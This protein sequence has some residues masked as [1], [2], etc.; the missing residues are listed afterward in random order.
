M[1]KLEVLQKYNERTPFGRVGYGAGQVVDVNEKLATW[2]KAD[3][4]GTFRDYV[5]ET[6][7]VEEPPMNKAVQSPPKTKA[8]VTLPEPV[9]KVDVPNPSDFNL[10]DLEDG[11][12]GLST[13]TEWQKAL[14]LE[15]AGKN[16]S[17]AVDYIEGK[18]SELTDGD[19]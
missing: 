2:L 16:R 15:G 14:E 10:S 3:S 18:I 17:G 4:P 13:L 5:P 12:R 8:P 7:A 19:N 6:K 1:P 11:L 9:K